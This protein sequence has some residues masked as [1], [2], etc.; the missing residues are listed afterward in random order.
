[1]REWDTSKNIITH[2]KDVRNFKKKL[3][4]RGI[5]ISAVEMATAAVARMYDSS[6]FIEEK[7]IHWENKL[8]ADQATMAI[9]KT[10]FTQLYRE[11]LQYSTF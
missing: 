9:V 11:R 7:M 5:A 2:C 8:D 4:L 10:Y 1:M 6:Y 3:D